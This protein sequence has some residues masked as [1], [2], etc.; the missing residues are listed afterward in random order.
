MNAPV[1]VI[2]SLNQDITVDAPRVPSAGE[3]ILG[4]DVR[5]SRGGKGGNQAVALARLGA[6]VSAVAC[7]G[8]DPDG[9]AYIAALQSE[10][11]DTSGIAQVEGVPTGT[12]LIT[13][14]EAGNNSIVVVP[15]ANSALTPSRIRDS[16]AQI[17]AATVVLSPL[18]TPVSGITEAFRIARAA[19]TITVLNPAPAQ[20]FAAI[21]DLLAL[22]DVVAP[23][24]IEFQQLLGE[25]DWTDQSMIDAC[26]PLFDLGVAW[27]VATLGAQGAAAVSRDEVLR[28]PPIDVPVRDTTAAGDSFLAGL[29]SQIAQAANLEADTIYRAGTLGVEVASITIQRPGAH[30]AIP[31]L[32]EVE[33]ARASR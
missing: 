26:Q 6:Q 22:S 18:E 13:V 32:A 23:N 10:G 7:V 3:T 16:T 11:C 4:T 20:D 2:A 29:S 12:A 25:C 14:E 21:R 24:E 19:G 27:V 1:T 15:G 9:K 5:F 28:I 8:N 31:T 33:A 30:T 17:Q